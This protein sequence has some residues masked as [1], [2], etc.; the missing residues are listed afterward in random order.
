MFYSNLFNHYGCRGCAMH[1]GNCECSAIVSD[2]YMTN[3]DTG[4]VIDDMR[5]VYD[6]ADGPVP[7]CDH[8]AWVVSERCEDDDEYH[9]DYVYTEDGGNYYSRSYAENYLHQCE[10]CGNWF[11]DSDNLRYTGGGYYCRDCRCY[12]SVICSYHDHHGNYYPVGGDWCDDLIGFELE[13]DYYDGAETDCAEELNSLFN[14]GRDVLAFEEDCSLSKGFE[15]ISHPHTLD[16]LRDFDFDTL[17]DTMTSY[18]A[19]Y[20]PSTAGLHLHFSRSWFGEDSDSQCATAGRLMRAYADNW[21]TLVLLSNRGDS[22]S[23]NSYAQPPTIYD[24]CSDEDLYEENCGGWGD[25]YRAVNVQNSNTIEFRLGAGCLDADYIRAWIE[26]HV[27]MIEAARLGQAFRVND[28]YTITIL[29]EGRQ[30]A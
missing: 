9:S 27:A 29:S 11:E 22:Y 14:R 17:C 13:S 30:A 25:R 21:D 7:M 4:E 16:A 10:D 2:D 20:N 15:T 19:C 12:H 5:L 26:L 18:G 24:E 1:T 8:C 3:C 23:I 6:W 28:D